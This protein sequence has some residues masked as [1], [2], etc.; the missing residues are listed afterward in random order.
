MCHYFDKRYQAKGIDEKICFI[1][2][3]H[4]NK[5]LLKNLFPIKKALHLHCHRYHIPARF[6]KKRNNQTPAS[7]FVFFPGRARYFVF[8]ISLCVCRSQPKEIEDC[9]QCLLSLIAKLYGSDQLKFDHPAYQV[10]N[11]EPQ[12]LLTLSEPF[13]YCLEILLIDVNKR[14]IKLYK[15]QSKLKITQDLQ[16]IYRILPIAVVLSAEQHETFCMKFIIFK[17]VKTRLPKILN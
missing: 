3:I 13:T 7:K 2:Q 11:Y 16:D 17:Y 15:E 5:G 10:G 1:I 9:D 6:I 12:L 14:C 4:S 8:N